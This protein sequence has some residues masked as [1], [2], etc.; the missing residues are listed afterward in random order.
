MVFYGYLN[1]YACVVCGEEHKVRY[2][3]DCAPLDEEPDRCPY[4]GS[5]MIECIDYVTITEKGNERMR[6]I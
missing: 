3:R 1:V 5:K 4:C 2:D 6:F